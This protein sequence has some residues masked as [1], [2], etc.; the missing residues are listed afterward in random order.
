M[1]GTVLDYN[2]AEG[3]GMISGEDGNR[4]SFTADDLK[5][6]G[7]VLRSSKVDFEISDGTAKDIYKTVGA[8]ENA[9]SGDKNK[10]VAGL[11]ALFLGAL[12][13]HKFYLGKMAAGVVMLVV[14]VFGWIFLG[15]PS[16]IIAII[17]FVEAIIYFLKPEDEFQRLYVEGNKAWF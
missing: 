11:L 9:F 6:S 10:L 17:A 16:T 7:K 15:I 14:F 12:G 5:G 13:I 2:E 3:T 1:K 8:T 4:Y